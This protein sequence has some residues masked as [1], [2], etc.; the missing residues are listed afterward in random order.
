MENIEEIDT[1]SEMENI[2]EIDTSSEIDMLNNGVTFLQSFASIKM[3]V[4]TIVITLFF[5]PEMYKLTGSVL[6]KVPFFKMSKEM[7]LFIVHTTLVTFILGMFF[8]F[9]D[10]YSTEEE[11]EE[12]PQITEEELQQMKEQEEIEAATADFEQAGENMDPA[13][14]DAGSDVGSDAGSD[15]GSDDGSDAGSDDG[16][17]PDSET[18]D[19][20]PQQQLAQQQP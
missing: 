6:K 16:S 9:M 3:L 5:N 2:E 4:I 20:P 7:Y 11:I 10:N 8:Y 15:A 19:Q 13:L 12:E 14:S 1:P 18:G 17:I